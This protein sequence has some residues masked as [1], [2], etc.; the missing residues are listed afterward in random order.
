MTTTP[1]DTISPVGADDV[2]T[3]AGTLAAAFFDD[4]IFAWCLPDPAR[5]TMV[6]PPFFRLAV[7]QQPCRTAR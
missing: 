1:S 6:L 3:V 4:P 7:R 5:R 2:P